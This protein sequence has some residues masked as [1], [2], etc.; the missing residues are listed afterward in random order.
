MA[1]DEEITVNDDG[2]KLVRN[3]YR[4][5]LIGADGKTKWRSN[6]YEWQGVQQ[7]E[8]GI[9]R[10][11][12]D[13]ELDRNKK[14]G[15]V[16]FV[17]VEHFKEDGKTVDYIARHIEGCGEFKLVAYDC[18]GKVIEDNAPEDKFYL[19]LSQR[20][21]IDYY[22]ADGKTRT[23]TELSPDK[24][25][26]KSHMVYYKSDGRT[27]DY[28][29]INGIKHDKDGVRFNMLAER[30]KKFVEKLKLNL[31]NVSLPKW[32]KEAEAKISEK[33]EKSEKIKRIREE[34][35]W[36]P[37]VLGRKLADKTINAIKSQNTRG[38]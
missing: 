18:N 34:H 11:V 31:E 22:T 25:G 16:D 19:N 3:G 13:E 15:F 9:L 21:Q 23:R 26:K 37:L 27:I 33:I 10:L 28:Q 24:D 12:S 20:S 1:S 5:T 6:E 8:T 2:S 32:A 14:Y 29:I 30:R 7:D 38:K 36:N 35:L 17:E 4:A